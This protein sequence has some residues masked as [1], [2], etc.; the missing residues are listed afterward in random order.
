LVELRGLIS[1]VGNGAQGISSARLGMSPIAIDEW[2]ALHDLV[3]SWA[4]ASLAIS[5]WCAIES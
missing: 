2:V 4:P 5:T 3:D 1:A